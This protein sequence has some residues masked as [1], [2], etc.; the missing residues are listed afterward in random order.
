VPGHDPRPGG[1]GINNKPFEQWP[2]SP[3]IRSRNSCG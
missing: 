3:L 2:T 1:A